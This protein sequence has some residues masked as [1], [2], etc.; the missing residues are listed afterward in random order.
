MPRPIR[1][2]ERCGAKC[3]GLRCAECRY[4]PRRETD[5]SLDRLIAENRP[6]M[7][8]DERL[9]DAAHDRNGDW[10]NRVPDVPTI[11]IFRS[12]KRWNGRGL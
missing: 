7:P 11:R 4:G 5:E 2:C 9:A 10:S 1:P 12:A 8:P 6:T 3:H